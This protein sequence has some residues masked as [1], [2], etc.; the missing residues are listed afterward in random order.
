M[1]WSVLGAL[2]VFFIIF[3]A[4]SAALILY[5]R[6]WAAR[7]RRLAAHDHIVEGKYFSKF[8][9]TAL[10]EKYDSKKK[11]FAALKTGHL[12]RLRV[13]FTA[14]LLTVLLTVA[15]LPFLWHLD[16]FLSP[17]DLDDADRNALT[18][19]QHTWTTESEMAGIDL[20]ALMNKLSGLILISS[21]DDLGWTHQAKQVNRLATTHWIH[22]SK[23]HD[24]K[25]VSCT[26]EKIN[27]CRQNQGEWIWVVL[28]G[29]WN[30]S[31]LEN[32]TTSGESVL[33]YGPPR[34]A[35]DSGRG[36]LE[37]AGLT[38]VQADERPP[39]QMALC[40]DEILTLGLDAGLIL[41]APAISGG[42]KVLSSRPQ[43]ISMRGEGLE[44]GIQDNRLFAAPLA[45]GRIVWFDFAPDAED[46]Y[47]EINVEALDTVI[48][49]VFRYLL[50]E[51]YSAW[52][53][54]P[55][56]KKF[57][58]FISQDTEDKF[59]RSQDVRDAL[60]SE[61]FPIT[62][63]MLSNEAL[64]NRKL[65]RELGAIGEVACHGDSHFP[66]SK[67][68]LREQ[69][70]RLARCQKVLETLTGERPVGFRPPEEEYNQDTI[71]AIFN[72]KMEYYFA[73][74]NADRAVPKVIETVS[75]GEQQLVSL[76]RLV[77]DDFSLWYQGNLGYGDS[78]RILTDELEWVQ[79]VGG[80][81]GFSFHSQY[82]EDPEHLKV[83]VSLGR[84]LQEKNT[85]FSTAKRIASWWRLRERLRRNVPVDEIL[86]EYFNP[87]R[88]VVTEQG[89]LIR[90]D[91][92]AASDVITSSSDPRH[93][94]EATAQ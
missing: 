4:T 51:S 2:V 90:G 13:V 44:R 91:L 43:G 10:H 18:F 25:V 68:G 46:H 93:V 76:P 9:P 15:G 20:K 47:A 22:F 56:G 14:T 40:G 94:Q 12:R 11:M 42:Y 41:D 57:A 61:G 81:Y 71:D 31:V 69:T 64:I 59:E 77:T 79:R 70:T 37:W 58:A 45:N 23:R 89:Q 35:I 52:A 33:L 16:K 34:Q 85:Y 74:H 28:P 62:W 75:S 54:W 38:F 83:V 1:K 26:W 29:L 86:V 5:I 8:V 72:T 84:K 73:D 21:P 66:F 19:S 36:W 55:W 32:L 80:L 49:T 30:F 53:T 88:L 67:N 17:I 87:V 82:M 65:T 63:F 3:L 27:D 92:V 39:Q 7:E 24:L 6:H 78:M 48:G 50:R 60:A